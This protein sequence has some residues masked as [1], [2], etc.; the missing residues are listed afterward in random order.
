MLNALKSL[1]WPVVAA[2][3]VGAGVGAAAHPTYKWVRGQRVL[4]LT[5]RQ[6]NK[7]SAGR[8]AKVQALVEELGLD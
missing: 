7:L 3:M 6:Y 1:G 2:A 5:K 8:K 4:V